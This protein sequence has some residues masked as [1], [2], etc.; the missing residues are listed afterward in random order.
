MKITKFGNEILRSAKYYL[1]LNCIEKGK[2]VVYCAGNPTKFNNIVIGSAYC[3]AFVSQVIKD[4]LNKLNRKLHFV[5][6]SNSVLE[7]Y[8][9]AKNNLRID[10][11]PRPGSVGIIRTG[12][13][14]NKKAVNGDNHSHALIVRDVND[15]FTKFSTIE[16]N[17]SSNGVEGVLSIQ[18]PSSKYSVN[19]YSFIHIED[20]FDDMKELINNPYSTFENNNDINIYKNRDIIAFNIIR[21]EY[22]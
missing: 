8:N 15:D 14:T 17:T 21:N 10:K 6:N 3:A 22:R 5:F 2:N 19:D 4:T 13:T 12:I 20:Y 1:D 9:Q 11:K 18:R 7:L 16:G